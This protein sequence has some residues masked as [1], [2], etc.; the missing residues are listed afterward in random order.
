M[1][2]SYC[3]SN[4]LYIFLFYFGGGVVWVGVG[5]ELLKFSHLSR[6]VIG[7]F[8]LATF[9]FFVGGFLLRLDCRGGCETITGAVHAGTIVL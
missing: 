5:W 6:V 9:C 7:F 8:I 1:K 4:F 3:L 2:I